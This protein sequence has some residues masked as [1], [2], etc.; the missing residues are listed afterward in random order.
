MELPQRF[1]VHA[2]R[3]KQWK[4]QLLERAAG[5]FGNEAKAEKQDGLVRLPS[6]ITDGSIRQAP[7]FVSVI[8]GIYATRNPDKLRQLARTGQ[9]A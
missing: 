2:N 4:D 8:V 9:S 5:V 6:G 3:I 7:G 1:E